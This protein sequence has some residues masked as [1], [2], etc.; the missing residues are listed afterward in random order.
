MAHPR[1]VL[2]IDIATR[3]LHGVGMA[4][5][6]HVVLRKRLARRAWRTV[7][8][9]VPPLRRG[10]DAWGSAHDGARCVREQ[11]PD[12]R[13]IARPWVNAS[14]KSP[15]PEARNAEAIGTAVVRPPMRVVPMNQLAQHDIQALHRGRVRRLPART[16]VVH[17]MRGL[18]HEYGS[19]L[20]HSLATFRA[21]IIDTQ[22]A[23]QA[24]LTVLS[25][26]VCWPLDAACLAGEQRLA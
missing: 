20:P 24:N 7:L 15:K 18:L 12:G 23:D 8:A 11:G 13:W 14:V 4:D 25:T 2:G 26:A 3:V 1:R 21:V 5:S 22:E 19:V 16:A 10:M 17:A 9:T 6:R